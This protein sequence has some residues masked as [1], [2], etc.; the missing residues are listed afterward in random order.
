MADTS[1]VVLATGTA[2][3][4]A[5]AATP[6]L[7]LLGFSVTETAASTAAVSFQEAAAT[8]LTKELAAISLAAS[9]ARTV[10]LGEHGLP[11]PLGI[12]VNRISGNTRVVVYYR[13]SDYGKDSGGAPSW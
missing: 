9:E 8:D 11:C 10:W 4:A 3:A 13:V 1:R 5:V 6:N 7:R 2:S 12:W